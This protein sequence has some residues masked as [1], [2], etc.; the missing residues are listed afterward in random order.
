MLSNEKLCASTVDASAALQADVITPPIRL[1]TIRRPLN[2]SFIVATVLISLPI[3]KALL[4]RL[5]YGAAVNAS[6][7]GIRGEQSRRNHSL[8][9]TL[10]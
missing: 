2:L 7:A 4:Q 8:P 10:R 5:I 9:E 6:F 3:Y 1:K